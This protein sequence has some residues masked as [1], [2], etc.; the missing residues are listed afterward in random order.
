[1][2]LH[3]IFGQLCCYFSSDMKGFLA[4]L[5]LLLVA[6]SADAQLMDKKVYDFGRVENWNCQPAIFTITNNS[7]GKLVF[8]PT[9]P[10]KDILV[11]L[12]AKALEPGEKGEITIGYF[13]PDKG[14]FVRKVGLFV[15]VSDKPIELTLK[16]DIVSIAPSAFTSCPTVA[17]SKDGKDKMPQQDILVIDK[18]TKQPIYAAQLIMGRDD[19]LEVNT[20]TN[21]M[22]LI[23]IKRYS[24]HYHMTVTKDGYV[25]LDGEMILSPEIGR[26]ILEMEKE[27]K[28]VAAVPETKVEPET[29]SAEPEEDLS[30]IPDK[31]T[32]G[33]LSKRKYGI[34]NIVFLIDVSNSM[35]TPNKLPL[36]KD[37]MKQLVMTMRDID[38]VTVISYS[39]KTK[40]VVPTTFASGTDKQQIMSLIDSLTAGGGTN[41]LLGLEKAYTSVTEN[42]QAGGNNQVII[43]TDGIF[44][45]ANDKGEQGVVKYVKDKSVEGITLSV[46]GF[47]DDIN[48]KKL[49]IKLA[50]SG[51]GSFIHFEKGV[52]TGA[53]LVNEIKLRSRFPH[54]HY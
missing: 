11:Q 54:K 47:G 19:I 44:N 35:K 12:P 13:T 20:T 9:Y 18:E 25:S 21:R 46:V 33:Q 50:E 29:K 36:L 17:P 23:S 48:A 4:S 34:N 28:P 26:V 39:N 8:L 5:M 15:N 37:A 43:A 32:T 16:G 10:A 41:G 27:K 38:K 6:L 51:N 3:I 14:P 24:G 30:G 31:D 42:Y 52:D 40:V 53:L 1:M 49:M 2:P 22:G 7:K 45:G